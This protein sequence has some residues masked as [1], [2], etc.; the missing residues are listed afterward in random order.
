MVRRELQVAEGEL[1]SVT[2]LGLSRDRL[3]RTGYF[4]EV[5]FATSR[6]SADD[7]INLNVK[8]EEAQT[9]ALTFGVGYSSL[10]QAMII[11]LRSLTEISSAWDT[12]DP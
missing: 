9:G 5:E 6:G 3:K 1:Y 2:G 10:Y 4:K 7:K 8:V 12:A 11:G